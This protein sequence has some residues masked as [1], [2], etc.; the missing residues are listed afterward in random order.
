MLSRKICLDTS[1]SLP[2]IQQRNL[3]MFRNNGRHTLPPPP[4]LGTPRNP[5]R[6]NRHHRLSQKL[7]PMTSL[8]HESIL[9]RSIEET[10]RFSSGFCSEKLEILPF[11]LV[12]K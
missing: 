12:P 7:L 6:T 4:R 2:I 1:N 8:Q 3:P 10:S 9:Q 11:F 5:R